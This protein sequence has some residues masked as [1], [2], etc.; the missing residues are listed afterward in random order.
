MGSPLIEN[1][2]AN[3]RAESKS[4]I[5]RH[6]GQGS[7]LLSVV[8]TLSYPRNSPITLST[9]LTSSPISLASKTRPAPAVE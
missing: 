3:T 4:R 8:P 1:V 9:T 5:N 6:K 7:Q 2:I